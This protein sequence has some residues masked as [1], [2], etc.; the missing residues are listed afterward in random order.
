MLFIHIESRNV[1]L[2]SYSNSNNVKDFNDYKLQPIESNE[3]NIIS[4]EGI[5]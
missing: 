5:Q 1:F 2:R 3:H 4:I